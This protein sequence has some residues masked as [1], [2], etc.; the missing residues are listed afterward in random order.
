M[1]KMKTVVFTVLGLGVG[2]VSGI[3]LVP[4]HAAEL[5]QVQAEADAAAADARTLVES[6]E[7]AGRKL[8]ELKR[9]NE[10][11]AR[12]NKALESDRR[13]REP[14]LVPTREIPTWRKIATSS[15]FY[16]PFAATVAAIIAWATLE[17]HFEDHAT[18]GGEVVLINT[19]PF[20]FSGEDSISLSIG[21]KEVI[22]P[23]QPAA[24]SH[25][26]PI[27]PGPGRPPALP[28]PRVFH[29]AEDSPQV[30]PPGP[31][32]LA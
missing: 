11:L 1:M 16:L 14:H 22:V 4:S 26:V 30:H 2:I 21:N 5:S 19:D 27:A 29:R 24:V 25:E 17:P 20:D 8:A 12:K 28:R 7:Q 6:R 10:G 18:I 31:L 9:N 15:L 13:L 32:P 3:V 23:R